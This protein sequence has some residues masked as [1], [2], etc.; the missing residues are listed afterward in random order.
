LVSLKQ[1][2]KKQFVSN[3]RMKKFNN[4]RENKYDYGKLQL[5]IAWQV[6][7]TNKK[8]IKYQKEL[9]LKNEVGNEVEKEIYEHI[10]KEKEK[11][12]VNYQ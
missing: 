8:I 1:T 4:K 2:E 12:I 7:K 9:Y 5:I 10:L 6:S 11:I 3:Q